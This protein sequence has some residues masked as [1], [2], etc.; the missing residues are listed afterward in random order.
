M[1]RTRSACSAVRTFCATRM[2]STST[3]ASAAGAGATWGRRRGVG[4]LT[5]G[6]IA[7]GV[8]APEPRMRR[9]PP[10]LRVSVERYLHVH[11]TVPRSAV[12]GHRAGVRGFAR[13]SRGRSSGSTPTPRSAPRFPTWRWRPRV[14][15]SPSGPPRDVFRCRRRLRATLDAAGAGLGFEF[16]ASTDTA[17]FEGLN[18]GLRPARWT[19]T[20]TLSSSG[21][22]RAAT[23]PT[24]ACSPGASP[25]RAGR[26]ERTS[27]STPTRPGSRATP[28]R[29]RSAWRGRRTGASWWW[30]A[31]RA[32]SRRA[33]S[34]PAVMTP[35]ALRWAATA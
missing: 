20:G 12:G 11:P 15:S 9:S 13:C 19:A 22:T 35:E 10:R 28:S 32:S 8:P 17:T 25:P 34:S 29:A 4:V 26:S 33:T 18:G 6:I 14:T 24:A 7:P 27:R 21:S 2:G 3:T 16:M 1:R 23:G 30:R 5:P 31:A